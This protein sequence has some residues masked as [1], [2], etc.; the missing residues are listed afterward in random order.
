MVVTRELIAEK[1]KDEEFVDWICEH[2]GIFRFIVYQGMDA[3][4]EEIDELDLSVR[5]YNCLKRAGYHT[6]NSV[7]NDIEHR[8]D[9]LKIRNCGRKSANEIMLKLFLYTYENLKPER[10]KAYL[11]KVRGLN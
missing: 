4:E 1:I 2:D 11:E 9:I 3:M 7:V 10:Q 5:S 6:I 8:E